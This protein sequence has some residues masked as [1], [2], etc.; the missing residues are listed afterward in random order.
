MLT[1]LLE[2]AFNK[3]SKLPKEEQDIL[4]KA[5]LDELEAEQKWEALFE[6]SGDLL[7]ELAKEAL[8]EHKAGKTKSLNPDQL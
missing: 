3:A 2:Q 4:A 7:E 8:E 1:K 6:K 5:I